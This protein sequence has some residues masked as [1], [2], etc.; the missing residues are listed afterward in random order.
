MSE[1]QRYLEDGTPVALER[2][3]REEPDWAA[4]RIRHME[5]AITAAKGALVE[6]ER[7]DYERVR[8]A[9][10]AAETERAR[11]C[12]VKPAWSRKQWW[13]VYYIDPRT[14]R[15]FVMDR[16]RRTKATAERAAD[17]LRA[18]RSYAKVWTVEVNRL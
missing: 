7:D 17:E 3:C 5:N 1:I 11:R 9:A 16:R 15:T 10:V 2:L 18:T 14:E 6:T 12:R 8:D 13:L 4:S